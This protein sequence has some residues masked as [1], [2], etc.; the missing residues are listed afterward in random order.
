M[1]RQNSDWTDF[2]FAVLR[3]HSE[4]PL[5]GIEAGAEAERLVA[6]IPLPLHLVPLKPVGSLG[7]VVVGGFAECQSCYLWCE[8]EQTGEGEPAAVAES[9]QVVNPYGKEKSGTVAVANLGS[10][11]NMVALMDLELS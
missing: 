9:G 6:G 2:G 3:A 10:C 11:A 8:K 1:V 4:P 5:P 7:A